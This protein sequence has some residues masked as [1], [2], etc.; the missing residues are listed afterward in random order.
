MWNKEVEESDKT[1]KRIIQ[2]SFKNNLYKELGGC[3]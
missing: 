2:A 3:I 1:G